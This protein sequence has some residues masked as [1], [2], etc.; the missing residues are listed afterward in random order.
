MLFC[1]PLTLNDGQLQQCQNAE[2]SI[3]HHAKFGPNRFIN[4][5]MHAS[6]GF[7]CCRLFVFVVVVCFVFVRKVGWLAGWLVGLFDLVGWLGGGGGCAVVKTAIISP[8]FTIS[9]SKVLPELFHLN[10]YTISDFILIN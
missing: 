1:T 7:C 2:L 5:R 8:S 4:V 6:V 10:F 9:H 3:C